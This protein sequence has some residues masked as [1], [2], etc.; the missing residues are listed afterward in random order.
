MKSAERV[1]QPGDTADAGEEVGTQRSEAKEADVLPD[2]YRHLSWAALSFIEA[3]VPGFFL[4]AM[5][6]LSAAIALAF[7]LLSVVDMDVTVN[8]P[9]QIE[10]DVGI[11]DVVTRSEG[12]LDR[13]FVRSG[14]YVKRGDLLATIRLDGVDESQLKEASEQLRRLESHLSLKAGR[15]ENGIK[16]PKVLGQGFRDSA[17]VT[18]TSALQASA[19]LFQ[20]QEKRAGQKLEGEL[21]PTRRRLSLLKKKLQ[22]L[23]TSKQRKLLKL[24][25]ENTEEETGKLEAQLA[26]SLDAQEQLVTQA[27]TE[28]VRNIELTIGELEKFSSSKRIE[29]PVNGVV[30][31]LL[32]DPGS[33]VASAI[34]VVQVV[35]ENAKYIVRLQIHSK[36]IVL[37][38]EGQPVHFRLEA[39]PHQTYGQFEGKVL[40]FEQLE[41]ASTRNGTD[42]FSVKADIAPPARLDPSLAS[43]IHYIVGMNAEAF[44]VTERKS[45]GKILWERLFGRGDR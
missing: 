2:T 17:L 33:Y 37:L 43:H 23:R 24:Y 9:G 28:L 10:T 14:Q 31:K 18:A 22:S 36:D 1:S 27:K 32:V 11:R 12:I 41:D 13:V 15:P 3:P 19:T 34:P 30:A 39:Y 25:I 40:A 7:T 42:R 20:E 4:F 16:L 29:S 38:K 26:A 8:G 6:I 21:G 45:I 5:V 35:P 44:V